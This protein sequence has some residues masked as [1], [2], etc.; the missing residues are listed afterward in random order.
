MSCQEK[1]FICSPVFPLKYF[2]KWINGSILNCLLL[3][4]SKTV[5]NTRYF[6]PYLIGTLSR[7]EREYFFP[8]DVLVDNEVS[9]YRLL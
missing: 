9:V 3:Y 6:P 1:I 7:G 2:V 4:I 5:N 8:Y